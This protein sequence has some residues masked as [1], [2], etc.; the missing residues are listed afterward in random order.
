M[1]ARRFKASIAASG[2]ADRPA[3]A[4]ERLSF[5]ATFMLTGEKRPTFFLRTFSN[6]QVKVRLNITGDRARGMTD[7][8]SGGDHIA[9]RRL[10]P[11]A[12]SSPSPGRSRSKTPI[13]WP[14]ST[15]RDG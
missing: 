4:L 6:G 5:F 9:A 15:G 8:S 13:S 11:S 10:R 14:P 2:A 7:L 1:A 3:D 12:G